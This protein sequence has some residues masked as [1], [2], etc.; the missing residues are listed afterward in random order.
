MRVIGTDK[1]EIIMGITK[2]LELKLS[3]TSNG[4]RKWAAVRFVMKESQ[5]KKMKDSL[6]ETKHTLVL[7]RIMELE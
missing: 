3:A 5:I 6:D 2:K 4:K 1:I 7:A